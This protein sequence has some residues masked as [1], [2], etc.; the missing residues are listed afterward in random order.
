MTATRQALCCCRVRTDKFGVEQSQLR[1]AN[2]S[3]RASSCQSA[4]FCEIQKQASPLPYTQRET[5]SLISRLVQR[6]KKETLQRH[7]HRRPV[8]STLD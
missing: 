4:H 1:A 7:T 6:N 2:R 3:G 5:A 8:S